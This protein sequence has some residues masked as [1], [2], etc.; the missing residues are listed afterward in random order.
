[1]LCIPGATVFALHCAA[2]ER[3]LVPVHLSDSL[4]ALVSAQH[5]SSGNLGSSYVHLLLEVCKLL[6]SKGIHET[7]TVTAN[8]IAVVTGCCPVRTVRFD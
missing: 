6:P 2:P 7:L 5:I 4:T 3:N 8:I 1:M